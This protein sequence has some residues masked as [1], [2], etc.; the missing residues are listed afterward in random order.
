MACRPGNGTRRSEST[1]DSTAPMAP[2]DAKCSGTWIASTGRS[3]TRANSR[4]IPR[5]AATPPWNAM[6]GSKSFPLAIEPRKL[7]AMARHRPA[8]MS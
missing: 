1:A 6:G 7:R 2:I 3:S 5:F 8:T 4:I